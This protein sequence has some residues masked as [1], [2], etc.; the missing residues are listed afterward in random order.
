MNKALDVIE[1]LEKN[2]QQQ[3]L[4][5]DS[6]DFI[7]II[8]KIIKPK[9]ILEIGTCHG[10]SALNFSLLTEKVTTLE[11]DENAVKIAEENFKKAEVNNIKL[12][13]GNA[14][15]TLEK[16]KE[17]FDII[18]IDAKKSEYKKYL[19]LSL[20]LLNKN[21]LI[22]V[23]NTISHKESMEDFFIFLKNSNLYY[24][25]LNIGKKPTSE[26]LSGLTIISNK[27]NS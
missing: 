11:I 27:I 13:E 12:I 21:S 6:I 17:K 20:E 23:D 7:S 24:Q 2:R 18:F 10:Y 9:N 15:E 8:C 3:Y 26:A 25:E 1:E 14:I 4:A 19:E 22:F 16:L 5:K